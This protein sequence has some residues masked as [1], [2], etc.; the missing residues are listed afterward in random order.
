MNFVL[1]PFQFLLLLVMGQTIAGFSFFLL[2]GFNQTTDLHHFLKV[3]AAKGWMNLA[4]WNILIVVIFSIIMGSIKMSFSSKRYLGSFGLI[5]NLKA[6]TFMYLSIFKM[7]GIP[8][9]VIAFILSKTIPS[10]ITIYISLLYL[11]SSLMITA[12]SA[13]EANED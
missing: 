1:R 7:V 11:V 12:T 13:K 5:T 2:V 8:I 6:A 3:A 9:F 4:F 10:L